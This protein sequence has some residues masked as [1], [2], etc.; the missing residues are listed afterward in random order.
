MG[1]RV[2]KEGQPVKLSLGTS[3]I[4]TL[5]KLLPWEIAHL[6]VIFPVPM[7]FADQPGI[8]WLTIL[9][10]VLFG[11]YLISISLSEKNQSIYDRLLGARVVK[12]QN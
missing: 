11:V 10:I 3:F 8:R 5:C 1:L 7:Y 9:G 2:Y 4:R 6:G 12:Q